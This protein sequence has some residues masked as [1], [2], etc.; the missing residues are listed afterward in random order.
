MSLKTDSRQWRSSKK[1]AGFLQ[2]CAYI[3][4]W[5]VPKI[6]FFMENQVFVPMLKFKR[7]WWKGDR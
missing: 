5:L 2:L 4:F 3:T 1:K 6:W 7:R